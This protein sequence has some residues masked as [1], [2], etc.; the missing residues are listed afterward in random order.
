MSLMLKHVLAPSG[1][2][3]TALT[4]RPGAGSGS[5]S[6]VSKSAAGSG[7][8]AF[9]SAGTGCFAFG[10][11]GMVGM[12]G[13]TPT[14]RRRHQA[15]NISPTVAPQRRRDLGCRLASAPLPWGVP[16]SCS[17]SSPTKQQHA[18]M[19]LCPHKST[20]HLLQ[21]QHHGSLATPPP[22]AAVAGTRD[23]E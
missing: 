17:S 11:A 6:G 13:G 5:T 21:H 18:G 7:D 4:L 9:T 14:C 23:S 20:V 3:A 19:N 12:A 8:S 1:A 10:L 15:V 2:L 22:K 16:R